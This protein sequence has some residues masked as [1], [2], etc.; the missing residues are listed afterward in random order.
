MGA[1]SSGL[2][3]AAAPRFFLQGRAIGCSSSYSC[4]RGWRR[5]GEREG[6]FFL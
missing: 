3:R 1:R 2:K 5:Y 6:L 4:S